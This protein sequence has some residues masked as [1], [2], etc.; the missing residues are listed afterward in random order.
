MD[1][2]KLPGTAKRKGRRG[3]AQGVFRAGKRLYATV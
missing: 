1:K 2:V 3:G